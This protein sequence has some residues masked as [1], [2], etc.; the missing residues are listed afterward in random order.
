MHLFKVV[1]IEIADAERAVEHCRLP[2]I[3]GDLI[4]IAGVTEDRCHPRRIIDQRRSVAEEIALIGAVMDRVQARRRIFDAE[5]AGAITP[6]PGGI[7]PLTIAM[8]MANTL[9]AAMLRRGIK[10]AELSRV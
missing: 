1:H 5:I 2:R 3:V 7:G 9:K 10:H 4:A 6:V 8:L